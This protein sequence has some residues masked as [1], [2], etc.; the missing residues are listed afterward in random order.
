MSE[1]NSR[2]HRW[3]FFLSTRAVLRAKVLP[4]QPVAKRGAFGADH[5]E[6]GQTPHRGRAIRP[7]RTL[8]SLYTTI[9]RHPPI[10]YASHSYHQA[11]KRQ[12]ILTS[13]PT[14]PISCDAPCMTTCD[15]AE[16]QHFGSVNW[17]RA[18]SGGSTLTHSKRYSTAK[19]LGV[20]SPMQTFTTTLSRKV[21]IPN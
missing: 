20:N 21:S 19:R 8:S 11:T 15:V 13:I 3:W 9:A 6:A 1:T 4:G 17:R 5:Q 14:H 12:G 16:K 7:P 10:R 2:S 18:E